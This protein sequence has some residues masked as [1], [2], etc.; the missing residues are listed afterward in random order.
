MLMAT[1]VAGIQGPGVEQ[2]AG[3]QPLAGADDRAGDQATEQ[4]G[5]GIVAP[6]GRGC[7]QRAAL[8]PDE[9]PH[10]VELAA[11]LA[12]ISTDDQFQFGIRTFLAG[13]QAQAG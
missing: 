7:C 11:E 12:R 9:F 13:L 8:P 6:A 2:A 5:A 4:G 1:A 3:D 10:T